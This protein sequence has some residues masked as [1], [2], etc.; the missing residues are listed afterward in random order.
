MIRPRE[1][2]K[3]LYRSVQSCDSRDG[4]LRLD[5]NEYVPNASQALYA[6]LMDALDPEILSA[7]PLVNEAYHAISRLLRQPEEKIVLTAGSDGVSY[8]TLMA[9]C[10]PGDTV[11]YVAPTY[12]MYAVYAE[13]MGLCAQPILY[14]LKT[15]LDQEAVLNSIDETVKVFIIANP[16]GIFGNEVDRAFIENL[17]SRGNETG[18]V[19]LLDEVYAVFQDMGYS[20]YLDLIDRYDNLVIARSF[21]KG[22][23]LAGV[24]AGY[25]I[26]HPDMRKALIAVRSNV[27][28]NAVAVEAI[29]IWCRHHDLLV[30]SV[31]EIN[32]AKA[33]IDAFLTKLGL[34]HINGAANFVLLQ[35]KDEAEW[36]EKFEAH[37]VAVKWMVLDGESWIRVTVG[38]KEYMERFINLLLEL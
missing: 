37:K 25:A 35:V 13:M 23:G 36:R 18:T 15:P 14:S 27:E 24:R 22:Y 34:K 10:D 9:F 1:Q 21:S 11:Y 2:L 8:S 5:M 7:Y 32:G 33:Y 19:I 30:Q 20:R 38:T 26:S 3:G 6:E 12:G 17:V 16:N 28:I 29:K 31:T 4:I